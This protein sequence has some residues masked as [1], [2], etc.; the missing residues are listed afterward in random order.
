MY[1]YKRPCRQCT[2]ALEA[3]EEHFGMNLEIHGNNGKIKINK[4]KNPRCANMEKRTLNDDE[5]ED[6]AGRH[7]EFR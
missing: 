2:D 6:S 4:I 7:L 3:I 5:D 1:L